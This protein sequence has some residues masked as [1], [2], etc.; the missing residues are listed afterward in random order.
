MFKKLL[1]NLPYNPSL[2]G[3]VSFYAKRMH[4][5]AS[6]RQ[7]GAIMMTLAMVLQLFAVFS[8]PQPTLASSNSDLI[9]GGITSKADA[10][11]HCR[12]NTRH[13]KDILEH[14]GITCADISDS[15]S[16]QISPRDFDG[17][18]YSMG[19]LAYGTAGETPVNIKGVGTLYLRHFWSLNKQPSYKALSGI[20]KYGM[21][22]FILY[23]CGNLV[24]IGIPKPPKICE[25][26]N[27]L[28]ASDAKCFEPCPIDGKH[29][30]PKSSDKCFEPCPYNK[31][32]PA[33]SPK[34]FEPC[35]VKGKSDIPRTSED[36]FEPCP[37]NSTIAKNSPDCKP[38]E[39]S[40]TRKDLTA[41]LEYRK[42]A[43][44]VTQGISDANGTTAQAGDV[45]EYTLSTH[46][47]GK[48]VIKDFSV[49]ENV[50]DVL[51][52]AE[53]VDL[54]GGTLDKEQ[55]ITW[56]Q[57]DIAAKQTLENK[58]T[59]RIKTEIPTTP[60]SASDPAHFD[61]T[62]TNVYGN[63]VNIT[64]PPSVNK[65][66]E[67]TVTQLPNTG[68][69]ASLVAGFALTVFITYFFARSRL[70]AKELDIVRSNFASTGGY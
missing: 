31:K 17:K 27:D 56:P 66:V 68:P 35:P 18:L 42:T 1:S 44:N 70:M 8:P 5:E 38:C 2:I 45:I 15:K 69:G 25:Y 23:D 30:I 54:H 6:V 48:A 3:Q 49:T 50:S 47:K 40:Q 43:A 37:Y 20:T 19:R 7:M 36:C 9:S 39:E 28:L 4:H 26:D 11:S 67:M 32:L 52:Y 12:Q 58:I 29:N 33:S 14:F 63:A 60:A 24:F 62:M 21:K 16:V 57:A 22:F 46:N 53:L 55:V 59:V 10:V 13:Y 61:M 64:L 41:C 34:C 65:S 51:D